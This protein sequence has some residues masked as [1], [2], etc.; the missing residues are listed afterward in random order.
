ML[1]AKFYKICVLGRNYKMHIFN[2]FLKVFWIQNL[3]KKNSGCFFCFF[4]FVCCFI[5]LFLI[6]FCS[7][8]VW[9]IVCE[10]H[11]SLIYC[12]NN[13][14][15][16]KYH[17]YFFQCSFLFHKCMHIKFYIRPLHK[18][19]VGLWSIAVTVLLFI[20]RII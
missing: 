17:K 2:I 6:H 3:C 19:Y 11:N 5:Y 7:Y 20:S 14:Y 10:F 1:A 4:V 8:F 13:K 9:F 15:T 16:N 18:S 12:I